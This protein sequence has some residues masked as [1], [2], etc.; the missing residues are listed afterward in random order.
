M[1]SQEGLISLKTSSEW[2]DI[3]PLPSGGW[4][5][6]MRSFVEENIEAASLWIKNE[7]NIDGE[8]EKG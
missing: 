6:L 4:T 5:P 1:S 8:D 7:E 2:A 3:S